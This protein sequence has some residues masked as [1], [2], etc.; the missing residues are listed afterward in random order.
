MSINDLNLANSSLEVKASGNIDFS[1]DLDLPEGKSIAEL[2][3]DHTQPTISPDS[4]N[5]TKK[6]E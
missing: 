1:K 2:L 3:E 6:E 5:D 4:D